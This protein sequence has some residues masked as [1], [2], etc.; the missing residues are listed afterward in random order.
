[1]MHVEGYHE[2]RGKGIVQYLGGTQITKDCIIDLSVRSRCLVQNARK[3]DA[4]IW[5]VIVT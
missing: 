4:N 5:W 1:M 2:Y 3:V